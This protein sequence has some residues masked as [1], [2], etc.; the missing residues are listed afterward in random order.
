MIAALQTILAAFIATFAALSAPFTNTQIYVAAPA[1]AIPQA[2]VLFGGDMMFDRSV[3]TAMNTYGGDF[4]LS[5]LDPVLEVADLVVANLEG[6]I[7]SNASKSVGS[8]PGSAANYVFTFA[9]STA[10]LLREHGIRMVNLGNNHILNF[11]N[12][13]VRSTIRYLSAAG[14]DYFG[15]PLSFRVATSSVGG[16][17]LAF[18]NY[19]EFGGDTQTTIR[20]IK[21]ARASGLIP[22][23]YTHWGVE[24]ATTSP[25]RLRRLAHEFVDAGAEIVFGSHPHVV[26][27]REIYG[28]KYIYYSLGNLIFD[29][30]WNDDVSHGLMV[31]VAFDARGVMSVQD[32][33]V[34]LSR[35]RRTCPVR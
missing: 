9:T 10:A 1:A 6:P 35:D 3:R 34:A 33:P 20:Q 25:L 31:K 21:E 2:T 24:Y 16:V 8:I 27:E 15:D 30:Y 13:G 26:E 7:T 12:A 18:I 23:V 22:V 19:N 17:H 29:Q 32:I 4:V 14:V 28:G 11:H 5:C